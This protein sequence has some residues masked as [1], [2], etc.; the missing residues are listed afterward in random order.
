MQSLENSFQLL[1]WILENVPLIKSNMDRAC[2]FEIDYCFF[3]INDVVRLLQGLRLCYFFLIWLWQKNTSQIW[4]E[5]SF[6]TW[7]GDI[8]ETATSFYWTYDACHLWSN[9][10]TCNYFFWKKSLNVPT[11][12]LIF[13]FLNWL[14]NAF[15][16]SP[17]IIGKQISIGCLK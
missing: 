1:S 17:L 12:K 3:K 14:F 11:V 6:G 9:L 8:F 2:C 4:F 10:Q 7:D 15:L 5:I 13:N 16:F